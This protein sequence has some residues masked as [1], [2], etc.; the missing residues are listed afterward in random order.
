MLLKRLMKKELTVEFPKRSFKSLKATQN[1]II[2]LKVKINFQ[3]NQMMKIEQ[4]LLRLRHTELNKSYS[5]YS[6]E[7]KKI[8]DYYM[9]NFDLGDTNIIDPYDGVYEMTLMVSDKNLDK[10]AMWNFGKI[11]IKFMKPMDPTNINPTHKNVQKTKMDYVF[12][13]ENTSTNFLASVICSCVILFVSLA[14]IKFLQ[15]QGVNMDNLPKKKN[16]LFSFLLRF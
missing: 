9:I 6:I 10:P 15:T 2:K 12:G 13:P 1:S 3:E 11:E 5:S 8:D 14:F 7:Y 4:I 16:L